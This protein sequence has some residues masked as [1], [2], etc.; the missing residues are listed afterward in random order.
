MKQGWLPIFRMFFLW[1]NCAGKEVY[2]LPNEATSPEF[3]IPIRSNLDNSVSTSLLFVF[4]AKR[5]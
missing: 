4:T 3:R 1:V 5:D 2:L